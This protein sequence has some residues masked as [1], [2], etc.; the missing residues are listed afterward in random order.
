MRLQ[1]VLMAMIVLSF[2]AS[3]D[4]VAQESSPWNTQRQ[5]ELHLGLSGYLGEGPLDFRTAGALIG[6]RFGQRIGQHFRWTVDTD[7]SQVNR[8]VGRPTVHDATVLGLATGLEGAFRVFEEVSLQAGLSV[9]VIQTY[10][11]IGVSRSDGLESTRRASTDD[12]VVM[13]AVGV[14]YDI[15]SRWS[16]LVNWATRIDVSRIAETGA[17]NG[18]QQPRLSFGIRRAF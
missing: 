2:A 13:P 16:L 6:L 18:P 1:S 15:S 5:I 12:F 7:L 8:A 17:G 3:S 10:Y 4:L 14:S 9:G 11:Q